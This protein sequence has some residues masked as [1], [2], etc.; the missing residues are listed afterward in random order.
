MIKAGAYV[1]CENGHRIMRVKRDLLAGTP[2]MAADFH[3]VEPRQ[4][5]PYGGK[6]INPYC[7]ICGARYFK[8]GVDGNGLHTEDGWWPNPSRWAREF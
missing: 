2:T 4:P 3:E 8:I 6:P 7:A 1:T 5:I